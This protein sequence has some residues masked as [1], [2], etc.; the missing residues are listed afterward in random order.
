LEQKVEII[1]D[2]WGVPHI[3]AQSAADLFFTQGYVHARDRLFQMDAGRR[4]GLGRLSEMLGPA[5]LPADRLARTLGWPRATTAQSA[6]WEQD[7]ETKDIVRAYTAGINAFIQHDRW[8][9]PYH[10]LR[11]RP[12]PW[13]PED[14]LAW[15]TVLAWG[16]SSNWDSELI[17]N[18]LIAELG[19]ERAADLMP[20]YQSTYPTILPTDLSDGNFIQTIYQA[21]HRVA[22]Q[23]PGGPL[24][25]GLGVGS[26][27]WVV[28]GKWTASGRPLLAND[29]HLP[30]VFPAIWYENHLHGGDYHVTGF[31]TPGVPG[32]A[33]GHNEHI[34]WGVTNAFP[35]IQDL[36]LI[37]FHP[38]DPDLYAY[39]GE[40]R[41]ADVVQETIPV[42]G[43]RLP[44]Q[45]TIRYTHH[46]PVISD[47]LDGGNSDHK[48]LALRWI[49]HDAGN[50]LRSNLGVCRAQNWTEFDAACRY[51]SF[52]S[53]NIV[54][55]DVAGHIGF[56]MPG[57]VPIRRQGWGLVPLAGDRQEHEWAG[58]VAHEDLPRRLDPPEG[59]IVTANNRIAGDDYPYFLTGEWLPPYRAQRIAELLTHLQP[60]TVQKCGHIQ[61]DTVSLLGRRFL[62]TAMPLLQLIHRP[63]NHLLDEVILRLEQWQ[64]PVR[65]S[66]YDM[67]VDAVGPSLYH[68]WQS[69]F[70]L[71]V[72]DQALGDVLAG[73]LLAK[74]EKLDLGSSP[75]F[76][77]AMEQALT[78][79]EQGA[80]EWVGSVRPLLYPALTEAV[81][82]LAAI[83]GPDPAGWQWGRLHQV[84]WRPILSR[85]PGLDRIWSPIIRPVGGDG[86]TVNQSDITPI[87]PPPPV[88][89]IASC[90]M[91]LD[92]GEWDRSVAVLPGGQSERLHSPHYQDGLADWLSGAFHPML[93]SRPQVV[94]A[95]AE[96]LHLAPAT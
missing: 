76:E 33:I 71:A 47:L 67:R 35:D 70:T 18:A 2:R 6:E 39:A 28:A 5:A 74:E 20:V 46:G 52:P 32:V 17:R 61:L 69:A 63:G 38:Q 16:L 89:T 83:L 78:W 87:F 24:P 57:R 34:A 53:L 21:F 23:V 10:V 4:L 80:P 7:P 92:V 81:Q 95:T 11:I 43:R 31:T 72:M 42:R 79:L 77:T 73:R 12:E 49:G 27:N 50:H 91:I 85:A 3:Y 15:G 59:M 64:Q 22:A 45:L 82:Q 62:T 9:L 68:A 96:V 54:Y 14:C 13:Q 19:P 86:F 48:N 36:Y 90:R 37:Q 30:P 93:F 56:L 51:W 44:D 84:H 94:A 66:G 40:W 8:P 75:F 1:Y 88:H 29:P 58:W 25:A 65:G 55:A 26:N 60:L 41:R